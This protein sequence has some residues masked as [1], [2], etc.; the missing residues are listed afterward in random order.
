MERLVGR[1]G[2]WRSFV[3]FP[4]VCVDEV[5]VGGEMSMSVEEVDSV[6]SVVVVEGRVSV[7]VVIREPRHF[8]H[9]KLLVGCSF[10]S[11]VCFFLF[12]SFCR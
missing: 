1:D 12:L 10:V 6:V 4:V 5:E 9:M 11:L 3:G 8:I 2:G 7:I